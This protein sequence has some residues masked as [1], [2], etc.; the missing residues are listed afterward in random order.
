[1]DVLVHASATGEMKIMEGRGRPS[2]L[3]ITMRLSVYTGGFVQTNG[4]LVE[5]ANGNFLID[6]PEGVTEW[7][8]AKAADAEIQDR[9]LMSRLPPRFES[10][11]QRTSSDSMPRGSRFRRVGAFLANFARKNQSIHV[12][13]Q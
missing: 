2:P 7:I 13:S 4:Y 6:A 5:T 11:Y 9:R 12:D 10:L 3:L 1:M 8:A